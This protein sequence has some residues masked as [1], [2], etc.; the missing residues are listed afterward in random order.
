MLS[1]EYQDNGKK[2]IFVYEYRYDERGNIVKKILPQ[3]EYIQYWYDKADR[4][5]F[6]QDGRMRQQGTYRFYLYDNLSRGVVEGLRSGC[7]RDIIARNFEEYLTY[8]TGDYGTPCYNGNISTQQWKTSDDNI[9]R[10]Y[11][12]TYDKLNRLV[13]S[14]YNEFCR[15]VYQKLFI[16]L[17]LFLHPQIT[18]VNSSCTTS[19]CCQTSNVALKLNITYPSQNTR[20]IA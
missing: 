18:G 12:F 16:Y 5:T 10:M 20:H 2:A 1:P 17:K 14:A 4:I 19:A 7:N 9:L 15:R 8:N 3:C 6:M 11:K 13:N